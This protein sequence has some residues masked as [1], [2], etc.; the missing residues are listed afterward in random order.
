MSKAY[1]QKN[2]S[3]HLQCQPDTFLGFHA[4]SISSGTILVR[5]SD[6]DVLIILLGLAGWSEEINLI[7]DYGSGNHRRYIGVLELAAVLEEE[8]P[9]LTEALISLH[10]LT[11]CDFTSCF[12]RKEKRGPFNN[13]SPQ[14]TW[15]FAHET[16]FPNPGSATEIMKW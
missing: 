11:G 16:P 9:G 3:Y 2:G 7:L 15:T 4:N 12:L 8:Q 5:S 6:T 13:L 10:A 1:K 14:R